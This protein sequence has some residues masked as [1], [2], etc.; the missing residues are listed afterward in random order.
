MKNTCEHENTKMK[1]HER[2]FEKEV[3]SYKAQTCKDCG[4]VLW[5]SDLEEEYGKWMHLL[6]KEKR[7]IFQIQYSISSHVQDCITKLHERFP[8][9]D[10]SLL[11][12]ALIVIY[13]E[14]VENEQTV[15]E[16]LESYLTTR[17]Y[18]TLTDGDKIAKKLQ[19]GPMGF[20]K[21]VSYA[22]LLDMKYAKIVDEVL[23]RMVLL[24]VK[25]D[26]V[27]KNFWENV[28]LKDIERIVMAA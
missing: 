21:I 4:A 1:K 20:H 7:H 23:N 26:A 17:D 24:S 25:E 19:F 28:I 13:I 15:L 27:M 14:M 8:N 11:I 2:L 3:F 5:D 22:K 16:R 9:V 6:Y 10:E 18:M 12:R